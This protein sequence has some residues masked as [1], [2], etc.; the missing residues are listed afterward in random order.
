VQ[1]HTFDGLASLL[2]ARPQFGRRVA[3]GNARLCS[4]HKPRMTPAALSSAHERSRK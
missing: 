1:A 4:I 2:F 3:R